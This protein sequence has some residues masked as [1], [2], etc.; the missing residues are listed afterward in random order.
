MS[1]TQAYL[2]LGP[3]YHIFQTIRCTSL[4]N[5]GGGASYSP[6]VAFPGLRG[7][8]FVLLNILPHFLLQ[9]IFSYFPPLKP[10]CVL[11][12]ETYG[13]FP[14]HLEIFDTCPGVA[15][16]YVMQSISGCRSR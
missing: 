2:G 1:Q 9:N 3:D 7:V 5:L 10:K 16:K 12:S 11:G 13:K 15:V 4:P 8:L 14:S 6:N